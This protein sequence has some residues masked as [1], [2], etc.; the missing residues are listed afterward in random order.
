ML[1]A[2]D[3]NHQTVP[4]QPSDPTHQSMSSCQGTGP[5]LLFAPV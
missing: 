2:Q 1:A 4:E 3:R 5:I